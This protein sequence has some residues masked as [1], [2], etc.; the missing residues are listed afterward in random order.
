MNWPIDE[1]A[2]YYDLLYSFEHTILNNMIKEGW[3][4]RLLEPQRL[5]VAQAECIA[6]LFNDIKIKS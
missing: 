3:P 2:I 4:E 1:L 6:T 5:K